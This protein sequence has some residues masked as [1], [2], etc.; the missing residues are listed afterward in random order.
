M[1]RAYTAIITGAGASEGVTAALRDVP[2]VTEAHVV[3]GDFDVIAEIE[4]ETVRDLQKVVTG[5]IH[6]LEDVGTTRTY[7]QM[8]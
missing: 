4:A 1:V 3:A 8:D 7:I 2:G 6:A 5:G